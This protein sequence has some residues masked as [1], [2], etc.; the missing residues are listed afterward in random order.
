MNRKRVLHLRKSE[1]FYG[2]ERVILSLAKG[3]WNHGIVSW[4]GCINDSRNPCPALYDEALR[5]GLRAFLLPCSMRLD[6]LCLRNIVKT[7][8]SL[9]VNVI[10]SHGFKADFYGFF[11]ARTL[12]IPVISTQHGWTKSNRLIRAWELADLVLLRR[13]SKVVGVSEEIRSILVKRGVS[14]RIVEHIP[15]GIGIPPLGK[16]SA[17]FLKSLDATPAAPII[18]IIGRLSME[19]GHRDFLTAAVKVHRLRPDARFWIVGGGTL[20]DDLA[21]YAGTLGIGEAVRFLDF[22]N[23]MERV[24]AHLD[25]VVSASLREG[26]PLALLEAMA[27]ARPVISTKVGGIPSFI[28]DGFNGILVPPQNPIM[29]ADRVVDLLDHP[30]KREALGLRARRTITDRFS[31]DRMSAEYARIYRELIDEG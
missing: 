24:C 8:V 27:M 11:A 4:I 5:Q 18:G 12:G 21:A 14:A 3:S 31:S 26:V 17:Q 16:K 6:P 13:F 29:M 19:K 2:A 25:I 20:R 7:A 28:R 23:D 10:H 22:R 9:K 1:G 15:N 30:L